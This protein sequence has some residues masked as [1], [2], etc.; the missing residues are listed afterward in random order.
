MKF[1]VK[2][3]TKEGRVAETTV[4]A[5]DKNAVFSDLLRHGITAISV[6]ESATKPTRKCGKFTCGRTGTN[7]RM[8]FIL[9]ALVALCAIVGA[10]WW[11]VRET[12]SEQAEL[13][14]KARRT[15]ERAPTKSEKRGDFG[16]ATDTPL[17]SK[18][19]SSSEVDVPANEETCAKPPKAKKKVRVIRKDE[20]KKKLFHNIADIYI[21][22]VVNSQPGNLVIGTVNYD[23]FPDLFRKALKEPIVVDKDDTVEE[24]AKKQAVIDT[25]AELKQMLDEGV[26]IAQV[27]REAESEVRRLWNYR[28]SLHLEL[29]KT[30]K[31]G[32]FNANDMQDY[33]DAANMMLKDNG[34][35]PLK[36]PQF[37][38][39]RMR[40]EEAEH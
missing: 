40:Q 38:I 3:R 7:G 21:S 30:M 24:V 35:A 28:R 26:D 13:C 39:R 11:F 10:I 14:R 15:S 31:E 9:P 6:H 22:R 34:M 17:Q 33:V 20:G 32:T 16:K 2:Y 36:H 29:V 18:S 12:P 27:M 23:R 8:R 19:A 4:E 5:T 37:W 1:C 25:R